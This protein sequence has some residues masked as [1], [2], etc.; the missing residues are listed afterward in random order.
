MNSKVFSQR[1]NRE[2]SLLGFPEEINEK[3][4]AV[5]KV[6][7]VTRH[8]ANA[9]IFGHLLPS[10]AQLDKIAE[11]LEVCPQW[12]CGASDRKKAYSGRETADQV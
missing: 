10:E 3:T 4:K 7:G 12:L 2:L 5:A 11:I 8:L 9:M 1:F 6:F